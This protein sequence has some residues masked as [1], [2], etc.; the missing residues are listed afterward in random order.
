MWPT[1][2]APQPDPLPAVTHSMPARRLTPA[3]KVAAL[4]RLLGDPEVVETH[5]SFVFLTPDRA[6]KLKKPVTLGPIRQRGLAHRERACRAEL[7]LNRDLAGPVYRG[8]VALSVMPDGRLALGDGGTPVDWLVEMDRLPADRMLDA[9]L[10][11]NAPPTAAE[12]AALAAVLVRFYRAARAQ[13]FCRTGE[14]LVRIGHEL[15]L[16]AA[17][18]GAFAA[19]VDLRPDGALA[20]RARNLVARHAAEIAAREAEGLVVDGHGD[21]RPEHVCLTD[22]PVVFDRIEFD[23]ALRSVDVHDEVG[24]LGQQCARRGYPEIGAALGRALVEAG[25]PAPSAGLRAAYGAVRCLTRAR[26]AVNHLRDA[27]PRTP[28]RWPTE[29]RACLSDAARILAAAGA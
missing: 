15:D 26:L 27:H 28:A 14:T 9:M 23:A 3:R 10:A 1:L 21:L 2:T 25:F 29:A 13:S 19:T 5:A 6:W 18:L 7:R 17:D 8:V 22:P 12:I 16:A 20:A 24:Y 4:I 11:R